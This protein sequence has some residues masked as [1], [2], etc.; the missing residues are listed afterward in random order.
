MDTMK[1]LR[2]MKDKMKAAAKEVTSPLK[3]SASTPGARLSGQNS[4]Y[5]QPTPEL[6]VWRSQ[7]R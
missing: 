6:K 2:G 1:R 7:Y 3:R 5:T 4:P